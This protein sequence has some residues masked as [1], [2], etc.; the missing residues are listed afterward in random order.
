MADE[1]TQL[2]PSPSINN[3]N[4]ILW[5]TSEKAGMC[6]SGVKGNFSAPFFGEGE[7]AV[8]FPYPTDTRKS[9]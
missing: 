2:F 4:A 3:P 9:E 1:K 7:R 8:V 5:L 6:L